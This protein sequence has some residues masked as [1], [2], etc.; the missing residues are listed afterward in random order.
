ME[1]R[2]VIKRLTGLA[3]LAFLPKQ[4]LY[5]LHQKKP[6]HIVGLGSAGTKVMNLFYS[7]GLGDKYTAI[8]DPRGCDLPAGVQIN[9]YH[10]KLTPRERVWQEFYNP[11]SIVP[12]KFPENVKKVFSEDH[13]FVLL[14]GLGGYTATHMSRGI[15]PLL[16]VHKKD[17]KAVLSLP[18]KFEG[19]EKFKFAEEVKIHIGDSVHVRYFDC[20]TIREKYG[21]SPIR[22]AFNKA[23]EEMLEVYSKI[24]WI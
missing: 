13:R 21:N 9:P 8:T 12:F 5:A 17:F 3:A 23:D 19:T 2:H 10:H 22:A 1:R 20:E 24:K 16:Q 18:F 11:Q 14:A 15:I 7:M 4:H 6:I